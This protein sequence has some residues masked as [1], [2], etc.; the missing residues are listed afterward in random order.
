MLLDIL[1]W[2]SPFAILIIV[3]FTSE[4]EIPLII[5]LV[6][7]T[8]LLLCI[9]IS[10]LYKVEFIRTDSSDSV[11]LNWEI[12]PFWKLSNRVVRVEQL[13]RKKVVSHSETYDSDTNSYSKKTNSEWVIRVE[14]EII[15]TYPVKLYH[16]IFNFGP[17]KKLERMIP[18]I[19]SR[20]YTEENFDE[21]LRIFSLLL[22]GNIEKKIK[23]RSATELLENISNFDNDSILV[24][25][26]DAKDKGRQIE[27]CSKADEDIALVKEI[28]GDEIIRKEII[29]IENYNLFMEMITE[30][31]RNCE[32]SGE[33]W[34]NN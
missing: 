34:W 13:S 19:T 22:D 8:I 25:L 20:K 14:D 15:F 26:E 4:G 33:E 23:V 9:F 10:M 31:L 2:V 16:Q 11:E 6:A 32:T 7:S 17:M 28:L 30:A 3:A 1:G 21:D 18:E 27:F 29:N 24:Y 12:T 5:A